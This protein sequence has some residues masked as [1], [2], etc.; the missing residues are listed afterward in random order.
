MCR[1]SAKLHV[2]RDG[3][4]SL[5]I[6]NDNLWITGGSNGNGKGLNEEHEF[7]SSTE[8]IK[9]D[10]SGRFSSAVGPRLPIGLYEHSVVALNDTFV[11]GT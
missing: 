4:A 1:V 2:Q 7:L 6:K 11:I 5:V 10:P 8:F 9:L 3:A